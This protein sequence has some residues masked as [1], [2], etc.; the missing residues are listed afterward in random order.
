MG[1]HLG[2]YGDAYAHTPHLDR[3]AGGSVRY[4]RAFATAPVCSPARSCLITG[5]YATSLNTQN[6]RSR[7]PIPAQFHGFP[8]YLR[9]LGYFCSNQVKTDYNTRREPDLIRE[10]WDV[11]SPQAH[12]RQR[13]PGQPFFSVINLEETHQSR[14]SVWSFEQFE[15]ELGRRL[16]PGQRHDPERAPVPPY[17]PDTPTARRTLA[18]YYD[19][20]TAMDLEV[21][22]ILGELE[23]DGLAHS[24][25]VF[26]FSDHGQGL[27]RGKRTLYDS[28]L[29]VPLLIRFPD[30]FQ[31]LAPAAPG[32][33][34]DRLVSFVDFAPTVLSLAG[35]ALPAYLQGH[36]FLGAAAGPPRRYVFGAR[37][38][39]DE[40]YDL[41]RSVRDA[42]FLYVRNY[43]PHRSL[44]QPEGY[45]D[46]ADLRREIRRLAVAGELDAVQLAYAGPT[47]PLEE[48][49]D[50]Q[51]DPQQIHNLAASPGHRATLENLRHQLRQWQLESL[52][53][54]FLPEWDAW[55]RSRDRTL[56]EMAQDPKA[57]DLP[58]ILAAADVV[59]RLG[60]GPAQLE[61]LGYRDSAVRFWA[62]VG[63]RAAVTLDRSVADP[64]RAALRTALSDAAL[65]VRIEAAASLA[66]LGEVEPA[67]TVLSRELEGADL[68]AALQAARALQELG[69]QARPALPAIQRTLARA[70]ARQQEDPYLYLYFSLAPL[71]SLL[72]PEHEAAQAGQPRTHTP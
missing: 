56:W 2:C 3:F 49:Y 71:V 43:Q 6:L 63:L 58:R 13:A 33:A 65:P 59:G 47:K 29:H 72:A 66:A 70:A 31:S 27:P 64:A 69:S 30:R 54:G 57:Y 40:A 24:T 11:C 35:A 48:L 50:T 20:I 32:A 28:G 16:A 7:F 23:A 38:R 46:Q 22:R 9:R 26:F 41:S 55:A 68:D 62:A 44:N 39:V 37:D 5:L 1:P 18:R 42:R 21:G 53:L 51:V 15:R 14:A 17:Y 67:L 61:L 4:T 19:C 34:I 45:S 25:I 10:S 60:A 36:A 52:D 8:S 12:W